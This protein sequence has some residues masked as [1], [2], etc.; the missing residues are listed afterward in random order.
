M[1]RFKD[2]KEE[3]VYDLNNNEA[4]LNKMNDI[5]MKSFY[6]KHP[7]KYTGVL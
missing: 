2:V 7:M 5:K 4:Y 1:F 3:I 6:G